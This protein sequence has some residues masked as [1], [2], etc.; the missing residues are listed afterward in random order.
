MIGFIGGSGF[1]N[2]LD[3]KTVKLFDTVTKWGT[4]SQALR[5]ISLD[6]CEFMFMQRHGGGKILPHKI[7]YQANIS[8]LHELGVNK[9]IASAAVGGINFQTGKVI[10]PDQIIDYTYSRAQTFFENSDAVK[11]IEFSQPY[12]EQLRIKLIKACEDLEIRA[13]ERGV[14]AI[15]QG[16]RL[17]TAAEIKRLQNDGCDIVGMT[18]MPEACLAAELD[19]KYACIAYIVNPAAG[20]DSE[21]ISISDMQREIKKGAETSFRIF[22]RFILND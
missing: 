20:V 19:I 4:P 7:N 6:G 21:P 15:T 2:F 9:I 18:G 16:P 14:H 12:N 1:E 13:E 11:H 3:E 5:K 22:K 10:I 17:E 8:A